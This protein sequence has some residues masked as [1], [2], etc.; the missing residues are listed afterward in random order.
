[1]FES[2]QTFEYG[3]N[4][5]D[6]AGASLLGIL[7][8]ISILASNSPAENGHS[9][10]TNLQQPTGNAAQDILNLLDLDTSPSTPKARPQ[11]DQR[12]ARRR[13]DHGLEKNGLKI[14][15]T[16]SRSNDADTVE[17]DVVVNNFTVEEF[18]KF[19]MKVAPIKPVQV[20]LSQQSGTSLAG[21]G[22]S[23]IHQHMTLR[24]VN[25]KAPLKLKLQVSYQTFS[26]ADVVEQAIVSNFPVLDQL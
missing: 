23:P 9:W 25:F 14:E 3:S 7:D 2:R 18:S 4:H 24:N 5:G 15:F 19:D 26:G 16:V 13:D 12:K 22:L 11:H 10:Q 20:V 1:M 6:P 17:V 8:D 21:H